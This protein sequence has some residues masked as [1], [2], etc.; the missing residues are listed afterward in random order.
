M[1]KC[2]ELEPLLAP[3]VDGEAQTDARTTVEA[4]LDRCLRCR[5]RVAGERAARVVLTARRSELRACASEHLRARC[6][7]QRLRRAALF[8]GGTRRWLP[9]SLAATLLLALSG[10]F[11]F[12]LNDSVQAVATQLTLDHMRCFQVAPQRLTHEDAA[13]ASREWMAARGWPLH[14]PASSPAQEL[15]LLGV[16]RCLTAGGSTAHLLYKW[17]GEPLSLFVLPRVLQH[18][19]ERSG[20]PGSYQDEEI[21]NTFGHEAVFWTTEDR[22]Y[23][24]LTHGRP[25]NLAPIVGY[26]KTEAR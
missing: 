11:V 22:T 20:Q 14:V 6:A 12:G 21:V 3:Y 13:S 25:A 24:V 23:V 18:S 1:S 17:R 2:K 15:E 16:R 26:M 9:L 7:A 8:A 4:H 5:Q 19:G 10:A